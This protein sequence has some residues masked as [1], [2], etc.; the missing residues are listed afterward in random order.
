MF[1]RASIMQRIAAA[2]TGSN[3]D[4][5]QAPRSGS[6]SRVAPGSSPMDGNSDPAQDGGI[7]RTPVSAGG[8]TSLGARRAGRASTGGMGAGEGE[9][10]GQGGTR[11]PSPTTGRPV[12]NAGTHRILTTEIMRA[13]GHNNR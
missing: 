2:G 4:G 10:E 5:V 8:T 6:R 13:V 1:E 3:P 12:P 7:T 11:D 9:G